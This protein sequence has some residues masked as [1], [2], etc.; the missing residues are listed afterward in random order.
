VLNNE[1]AMTVLGSR[2]H[3]KPFE[4]EWAFAAY[5]KQQ[6]AHWLPEEVP[7]NEDVVDYD[8]K[9]S[10]GERRVVTQSLRLFTQMDLDVSANYIDHLIGR[11]HLPEVRMMLSAFS[12]MESVHAQ[13]YAYL[14]DSLNLDRDSTFYAGFMDVPAMRA[15]HEYL[16]ELPADRSV[17]GLAKR[18]A[19]FG[20]FVEGVQL[21]SSFAILNSFPRRNLM[22]G[23]GQIITWSI[24]DE[25]LHSS[26]IIR[27]FRT[28]VEEHPRVWT[29]DL[30]RDIYGACEQC[31]TLEDAFVD[32]CFDL[33]DITG[34]RAQDVKRYVRYMANVRLGEL[35]LKPR[36]P[37][38]KANPFLWL[39]AML[40]Q[41]H[42]NFFENRETSYSKGLLVDDL[43]KGPIVHARG[44]RI[45][46]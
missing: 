21:F 11:F 14:S 3:Y 20:G 4:Y 36:W 29:D 12:A 27:L 35:G 10:E 16:A 1:V 43:P 18:L 15:K 44:Q 45:Q 7:M 46:L 40:Q 41:T 42:T 33:G 24:R 25:S 34:L 39:D 22:K 8:H 19:V 6:Q 30:K 23:T 28:V 17:A 37:D 31:V 13:A 38:A 9:L 2:V 32:A 26:S 5:R